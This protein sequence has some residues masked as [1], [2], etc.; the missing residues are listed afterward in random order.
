MRRQAIGRL[1][2]LSV[3]TRAGVQPASEAEEAAEA[4]LSAAESALTAT[5][6]RL[7]DLTHRTAELRARKG[8]LA[9]TFT[10]VDAKK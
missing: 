10:P 3:A 9:L 5:E 1:L 2:A 6:K 7:S 8:A 4:R